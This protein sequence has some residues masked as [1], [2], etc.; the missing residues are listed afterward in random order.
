MPGSGRQVIC[1]LL[2]VQRITEVVERLSP[3]VV[4]HAQ[5]L[6]DVDQCERE[7]DVAH[8]QNVQ[9]IAHLIHALRPHEPLLVHLST[10]YVFDGVKGAPYEE[11]DEPKPIS[12]YGASKLEAEGLV[13]G[14]RRSVVVRPST[15]F[16]PGRMN[17]CDHIISRLTAKQEVEAFTDQ[18]TSP[19]YTEDLAIAI[20]ELC[21]VLLRSWN[22]QQPRILHMANAGAISRVAFAT[23]VADL[24]GCSRELI[25]GIPMASQRRPAR[26]PPYSAL[27]T[28]HLKRVIG[29]T[30]RPWDD[31]LQA[32]L[33]Q[34]HPTTCAGLPK[35]GR[36]AKRKQ[37]E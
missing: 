31:A 29:R 30:L 27:T 34:R 1:D 33:R 25:Q 24:L 26:R 9:T 15:L 17:F 11:G 32:Y 14:Y 18:V 36:E 35:A 37:H 23:R 20:G 19:T 13:L 7:P 10:D 3:D 5:A 6:S 8:A 16:G 2:N 28:I 12:V 22:T 21:A 4:I